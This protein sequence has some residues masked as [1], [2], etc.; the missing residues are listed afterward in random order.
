MDAD[1]VRPPGLEANAEQ[2]M[3]REELEDVEGRHSFAR[4]GR[5]EGDSRR[6]AA[7]A[8]YR[9]LDTTVLRARPA[10]NEGQV[11]PLDP[12]LAEQPLQAAVGFVRAGHHEQARRVT[13]EPVDDPRPLCLPTSRDGM[14]QQAVNEGPAAVP[15]GRMHDDAG[16]LVDDEQVVVLVREA[17]VELLGL[18]LRLTPVRYVEL[19]LLPALEP[20][21]LG[22]HGP[23]HEHPPLPEEPLGGRAGTYLLDTGQKAVEAL[24]GRPRRHGE[25]YIPRQVF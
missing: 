25:A 10:A 1:L 21:A 12:P 20:V 17:K 2:R 6:V 22:A 4:R 24:A 19:H 15:R 14:G 23:V 5:I 16:G 3:A 9:G 13:V 11:L 7:I 18:E 8:A